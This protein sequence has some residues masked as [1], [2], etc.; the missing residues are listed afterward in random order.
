M[1][2]FKSD[3]FGCVN[4]ISKQNIGRVARLLLTASSKMTKERNGLNNH[5]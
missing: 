5:S 2:V 3:K 1:E 4:G